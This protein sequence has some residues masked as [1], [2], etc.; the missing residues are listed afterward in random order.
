MDTKQQIFLG[1][2]MGKEVK[3][4]NMYSSQFFHV[5]LGRAESY[6]TGV[7]QTTRRHQDYKCRAH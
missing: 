4:E 7:S 2:S 6:H 5:Q 3:P 1:E